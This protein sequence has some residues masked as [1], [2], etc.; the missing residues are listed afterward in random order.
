MAGKGTLVAY[1]APP[2][3][4]PGP[5]VHHVTCVP[6]QQAW[7]ADRAQDAIDHD[8]AVHGHR[9]PDYPPET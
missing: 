1:A 8:A 3:G 6:C 9:V 4:A 2:S 7:P 5:A